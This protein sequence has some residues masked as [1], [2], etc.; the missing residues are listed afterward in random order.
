MAKW[1]SILTMNTTQEKKFFCPTIRTYN[2]DLS[3]RWRIEYLVPTHN[4]FSSK[5]IV[6]YGN[7]NTG[8]TIE[9]RMDLAQ[10]LIKS[11]KLGKKLKKATLLEKVVE[12][13]FLS[14]RK[15]TVSAYSTVIGE[16]QKFLGSIKPIHATQSHIQDFL[17]D[18]YRSGKSNNTIAKYRNTLYTLYAKAME[19][20]LCEFNPVQK[21]PGIKRVPQSLHYFTDHQ[22]KAI[23]DMAGPQLLLCIKLLYYC[24]IRPG[25]IRLLKIE[26]INFEY[27]FIEINGQ[28]SKNKKAR[29]VQIPRQFLA[30]IHYLTRYSNSC[31]VVSKDL[32]PG[33]VPVSDKWINDEHRKILNKLQIRGRYAFYSWKHTGAV[34][35]V[36]NGINIKDLQLQL[37]HHSLDMVNEYLKN[38]G[39]LDSHDI[40]DKFPTL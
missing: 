27:G 30:E 12:L 21:V 7:I 36:K 23:R 10:I 40:R 13:N 25:E 28:I 6:L 24:F 39:V 19:H 29:K 22:I 9:N 11:L 32:Q 8:T 38:L 16:F 37:G 20:G 31:Y 33:Q 15:K 17:V 14:W 18:Q 2:N 1:L 35:A 34:K 5:R 4:G 26:D 3:K